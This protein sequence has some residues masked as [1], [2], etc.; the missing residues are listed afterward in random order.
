V[1]EGKVGQYMIGGKKTNAKMINGNLIIQ[2]GGGWMT[3]DEYISKFIM[4]MQSTLA[5]KGETKEVNAWERGSVTGPKR[6]SI[7]TKDATLGGTLGRH[8]MGDKPSP[9]K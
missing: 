5:H 9:S 4:T 8:S 2:V 7:N 3:L 6:T 1:E